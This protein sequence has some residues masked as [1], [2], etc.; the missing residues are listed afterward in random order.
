RNRYLDLAKGEDMAGDVVAA[1]RFY[2]YAEHYARIISAAR[3]SSI[4][5]TASLN[6]ETKAPVKKK[7][8]YFK[9]KPFAQQNTTEQSKTE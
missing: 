3:D 9:R 6:E 2:Q 8:S 1:Q 5:N 7:I 4:P